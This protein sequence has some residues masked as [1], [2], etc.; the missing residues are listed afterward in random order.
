MIGLR[1]STSHFETPAICPS[2]AYP[3]ALQSP[4]WAIRW[5]TLSSGKMFCWP[6]LNLKAV[7]SW[8]FLA[9][10]QIKTSLFFLWDSNHIRVGKKNTPT[11]FGCI[12]CKN[13]PQKPLNS[14]WA[15]A[16]PHH[17]LHIRFWFVWSL[18]SK[19]LICISRFKTTTHLMDIDL[20]VHTSLC[21]L[22]VWCEWWMVEKKKPLK[23]DSS[24]K[25]TTK[26]NR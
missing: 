19:W 6:S 24:K 4:K 23:P 21:K 9:S 11:F 15:L 8:E 25:N 3:L 2:R 12:V 7:A 22:L 5:A 10:R 14:W 26:V 17:V 16:T 1:G 13:S 20:G 18:L